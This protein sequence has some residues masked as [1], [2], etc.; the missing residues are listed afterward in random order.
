MKRYF[1]H[2]AESEFGEGTVFFEITDDWPS[3][4]VE[5]YGDEWRWG[6]EQHKEFLADKPFEALELHDEH[7]IEAREFEK[8]WQ[9][10]R[11]RWQPSS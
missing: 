4:Q 11:R 7:A 2:P 3:R 6:D 8:A 10:G 1:K 9:E 5:A